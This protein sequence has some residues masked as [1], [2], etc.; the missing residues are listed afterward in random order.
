M[1]QPSHL[2]AGLRVLL[3][4]ARRRGR[5]APR[6][7]DVPRRRLAVEHPAILPDADR[8]R[9]YLQV[10]GGAGIAGTRDGR[11][12]LPPTYSALWETAL[13]L[14][15]LSL[16]DSL[17]PS[18][19]LVHTESELVSVRPLYVD[20]RVRC[21]VEL[22]RA[23][24]TGRGTRLTL[25]CRGWNGSGQLCQENTLQVLL[26]RADGGAERGAER[27]APE[28]LD[29]AEWR[30]LCS[31]ELPA[32]AGRRYAR[33][34]GDYNPIHLWGWSSRLLGF[35]RP[36]LHGF[37]TE[38]MVAHALVER[39]MGGDPT[40]LRRLRIAFRSPLFLPARAR[41][42]IAAGPEGSGRFRV[43]GDGARRPYAE[44]EWVG[45]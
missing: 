21:R 20:D 29:E 34:S 45:G 3:E 12:P 7:A 40:S 2:R 32:S 43:A 28:A 9:R 33:V 44:G 26:P 10:T 22:E 31:W 42:V 15:L 41:L 14:E 11:V 35:D 1:A 18:R 4:A 27:R 37:C 19:G 5:A 30:E 25:Q 38:A 36:V 39:L 13:A 16:D 8:V 24:P 23:E 6:A 17:L